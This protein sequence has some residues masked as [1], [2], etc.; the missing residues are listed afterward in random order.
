M[1][2]WQLAVNLADF[3][4]SS[5]YIIGWSC[6]VEVYSDGELSGVNLERVCEEKDEKT[7]NEGGIP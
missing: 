5:C 3:R 6:S 1:S 2:L 4:K 7:K